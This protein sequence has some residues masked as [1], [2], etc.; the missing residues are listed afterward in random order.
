MIVYL[1]KQA[2]SFI[3]MFQGFIPGLSRQSSCTTFTPKLEM[4]S[5]DLNSLKFLDGKKYIELN[6]CIF[7]E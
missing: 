6:N 2:N 4:M 5:C 1:Q 7:N 3:Q